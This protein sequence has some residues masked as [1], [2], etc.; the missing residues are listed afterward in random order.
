M[1]ERR[2]ANIYPEMLAIYNYICTSYSCIIRL[3]GRLSLIITVEVDRLGLRQ[4][5]TVEVEETDFHLHHKPFV[6]VT[7]IKLN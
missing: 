5:G 3:F 1:K 6:G 7:I 2:H 4:T